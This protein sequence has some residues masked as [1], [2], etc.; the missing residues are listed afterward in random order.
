MSRVTANATATT[1][2]STHPSTSSRG[3]AHRRASLSRCA[4]RITATRA[5]TSPIQPSPDVVDTAEPSQTHTSPVACKVVAFVLVDA[6]SFMHYPPELVDRERFERDAPSWGEVMRH[7]AARVSWTASGEPDEPNGPLSMT[8]VPIDASADEMVAACSDADVFIA[9]GVSDADVANRIR[10]ATGTVATGV[11]FDSPAM[12]DDERICYQPI[13]QLRR[14]SSKLIPWSSAARDVRLMD[15]IKELYGRKNHLDLLLLILLLVDASG[16]RVPAVDI[17]QDITLS[18]VWCIASNC[19]KQLFACYGNPQCKKSLDCVD[20]CGLN[21]QFCTYT[22]LRSYQNP[23]FEYLARCMLHKH[24][25]LSNSAVRPLLPQVLPMKTWRGEPLTHDAAERIMQGHFGDKKYSWLA[26]AG[27]N[28]AY[29][30][31]P[32]QFQI[33]YRGKGR[34]SFWY[35]PV[36]KVITLDGKEVWRRSDYRVRRADAPGTF[37]FTFMDNGVTSEEYWRIVDAADDLSWSLYYYAGAARSAGQSYIGAVL[38]TPD[39]NWP[40]DDQ[41][42]RIE[43]SLWR[44]CGVKLWE[45]CQVDNTTAFR[46]DAPLEP[47]HEPVLMKP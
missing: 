26:V 28:P 21:D 44:G 46:G 2:A 19:N 16:V 47:L 42:D 7:M 5:V 1:T 33:W 20:A 9:V 13:N 31:F 3:R 27:Q 11:A 15:Q 43:D 6:D 17:N 37:W 32:N 12:E 22:C 25:C 29:D 40:A 23:E 18:N 38:A 14:M 45:M 8:V 4:R 41:I 24:N 34:N 36:F 30:Y 39:G 10:A 35:N